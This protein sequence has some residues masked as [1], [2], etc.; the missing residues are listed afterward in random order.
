MTAQVTVRFRP[1]VVIACR[2]LAGAVLTSAMRLT[3]GPWAALSKNL[4]IGWAA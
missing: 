1:A 2:C 3:S 4:I